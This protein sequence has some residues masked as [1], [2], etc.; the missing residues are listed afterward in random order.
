MATSRSALRTDP[1]KGANF[2]VGAVFQPGT[3]KKDSAGNIIGRTP[4]PN[5]IVPQSLW[6][7]NT[8]AFL[9]VVNSLNYGG[10]ARL[11]NS[12]DVFRVPLQDTYT[13][14]KDGKVA[15]I[16]CNISP[17]ATCSSA[18]LTIYSWSINVQREI[19]AKTS[20]D[21]AYVGNTRVTWNTRTIS[22][23][24]LS[25]PR[26]GSEVRP[27]T[28]SIMTPPRSATISTAIMNGDLPDSIALAS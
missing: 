2:P 3:I 23:R 26:Y 12:P 25:E 21:V 13:F 19:G 28:S 1:I 10:G 11:P 5:N 9:R 22:V 16:D 20:L 24:C 6:A 27:P 7:K 15:C 4:F 18:G 8:P 14:Q 17:N